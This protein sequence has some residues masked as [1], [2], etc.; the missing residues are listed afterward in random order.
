MDGTPVATQML[1]RLFRAE[2][3]SQLFSF[4]NGWKKAGSPI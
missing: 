4:E 3:C 1:Q 2:Q